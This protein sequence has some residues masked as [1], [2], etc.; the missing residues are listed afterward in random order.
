MI[1]IDL[2]TIQKC[3]ALNAPRITGIF[4]LSMFIGAGIAAGYMFVG[5]SF[6]RFLMSFFIGFVALGLIFLFVKSIWWV[7]ANEW[8]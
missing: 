7:Y 6:L 4:V 8:K 1:V 5:E 3:F 2:T